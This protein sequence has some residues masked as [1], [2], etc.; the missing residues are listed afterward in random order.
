MCKFH[1]FLALSLGLF[2]VILGLSGTVLV[3]R[4]ELQ[5]AALPQPELAGLEVENDAQLLPGPDQLFAS[6]KKRFPDARL[7]SVLLPQ[8]L[9]DPYLM[10]ISYQDQGK[11][12]LEKLLVD[13]LGGKVERQEDFVSETEAWM[14]Q[15]HS[16]L[17]LATPG[18]FLVGGIGIGLLV[19]LLVG[20]GIWG[21][22]LVAAGP[23]QA[24]AW[25]MISGR[26][27]GKARLSLLHRVFG[28]YFAPLLLLLVASGV[29]LVFRAE[30]LAPFETERHDLHQPDM[31][32]MAAGEHSR[33]HSGHIQGTTDTAKAKDCRGSVG[34]PV[35]L[36]D[37]L[38]QAELVF[39]TGNATFVRFP[40]TA[41]LP[42]SVTLR[43]PGE[44][45][46]PLGLSSVLLERECGRVV[47]QQNGLELSLS[48]TLI[49]QI[50]ALHNG[51][52][53]GGA[54]RLLYALAGIL[55]L[56]FMVTG[57]VFWFRRK[58][59][60]KKK[61]ERTTAKMRLS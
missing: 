47:G 26:A 33:D 30:L 29:L 53:W 21:Q 18:T 23:E 19:L 43:Q 38:Y 41:E 36:E 54:G 48:Q 40:R 4:A 44:V 60:S 25:L 50:V 7:R 3:F 17:F 27:R 45:P 8:R 49:E 28:F 46:S 1:L 51:S 24:K 35:G 39:P 57:T 12:R 59:S 11:N 22:G 34:I 56:F 37:Y 52:Y 31:T 14:Y 20:L 32:G 55:P 13:S 16:S 2:F 6:V 9:M 15:L 42:V 61:T 58:N 10:T 5:Q